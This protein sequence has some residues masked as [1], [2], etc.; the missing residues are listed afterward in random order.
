MAVRTK[1]GVDMTGVEQE[2]VLQGGVA[3]AGAVVWVGNDVRGD[4]ER[5]LS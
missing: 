2:E 4:F 5:A 3:N 1:N